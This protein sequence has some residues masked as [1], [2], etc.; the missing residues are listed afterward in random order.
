MTIYSNGINVGTCST[1]TALKLTAA[2]R[3]AGYI[4]NVVPH[5]VRHA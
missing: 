1:D 5:V 3:A 2:L 4:V